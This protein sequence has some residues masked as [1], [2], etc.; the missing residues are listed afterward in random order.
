MENKHWQKPFIEQFLSW[1]L[2]FTFININ[3]RKDVKLSAFYSE[4]PTSPNLVAWWGHVHLYVQSGS[5]PCCEIWG[6]QF[7]AKFTCKSGIKTKH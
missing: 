5:L 2:N 4:T 3:S 1:M 7:W 6:N